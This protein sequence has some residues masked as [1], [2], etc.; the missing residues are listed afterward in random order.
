MGPPALTSRL[1]RSWQASVGGP[2]R[3]PARNQSKP[4]TH[5]W[6]TSMT[7]CRLGPS[8]L[9]LENAVR[10]R[11]LV[12]MTTRAYPALLN[13]AL[14]TSQAFR[15]LPSSKRSRSGARL[16]AAGWSKGDPPRSSQRRDV[17]R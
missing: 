15:L 5:R 6:A 2:A 14:A 10:L 9:P 12:G 1:G 3:P 8:S 13:S 11:S 7:A 4:A 16:H 17:A